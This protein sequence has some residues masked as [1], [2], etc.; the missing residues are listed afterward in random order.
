MKRI[1]AAVLV[2]LS[3]IYACSCAGQETPAGTETADLTE[4]T[5]E[6]TAAEDLTAMAS[7]ANCGVSLLATIHAADVR[8]LRGKPLFGRLLEMGV[9]SRCVVIS[10]AGGER[11]YEVTDL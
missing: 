2:I 10:R 11:V 8:E 1:L 3:V 5:D 9:F 4:E 7:A 6:I